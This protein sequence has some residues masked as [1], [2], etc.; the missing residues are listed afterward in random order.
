VLNVAVTNTSAASDLRVYP[1]DSPV[2]NTA[3]INWLP[4]VTR[5]NLV[6]VKVGPDGAV[7]IE[8]DQGNVDVV[9][10]VLGWFA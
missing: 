4:G 2:T 3:D 5:S 9:I 6:P 7:K 1:S 10:D 8:N